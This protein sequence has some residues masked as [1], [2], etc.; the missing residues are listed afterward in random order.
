MIVA[1]HTRTDGRTVTLRE[2]WHVEQRDADG[3]L[4]EPPL[5]WIAEHEHAARFIYARKCVEP[6]AFDAEL[7]ADVRGL[8]ARVR[9]KRG[10]RE[11]IER[12]IAE[13]R[14]TL[15]RNLVR[16]FSTRVG[17]EGAKALVKRITAAQN[18]A[19]AAFEAHAP[20]SEQP[21]GDA[22]GEATA[23][24]SRGC[25]G[26]GALDHTGT[27]EGGGSPHEGS[28]ASDPPSLAPTA[29]LSDAGTK[30]THHAD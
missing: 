17:G 16:E 4:V 30:G 18:A 19:V 21:R 25:S 15:L 24:P 23:T 3:R 26:A 20:A 5:D 13:G 27:R 12:A 29:A 9:L 1:S 11:G 2:A 22:G 10:E 28:V 6:V 14:P 7:V 8:A